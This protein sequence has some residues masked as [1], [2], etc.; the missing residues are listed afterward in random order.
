MM[1]I[2][3]PVGFLDR[4]PDLLDIP[5]AATWFHLGE[6][7]QADGKNSIYSVMDQDERRYE[8]QITERT[9]YERIKGEYEYLTALFPKCAALPYPVGF[10]FCAQGS[11]LYLQTE[12]AQGRPVSGILPELPVEWQYALGTEAGISLKRIHQARLPSN[13]V[14]RRADYSQRFCR[15]AAAYRRIRL[16]LPSIRKL[17]RLIESGQAAAVDRQAVLLH[18]GFRL[19]NLTVSP[20]M[21]IVFA[22][23]R[24]WRYGDPMQDLAN[25]LLSMR[26]ASVPFAIGILDAYFCFRMYNV[27]L[28]LLSGYAALELLEQ[29]T[30]ACQKERQSANIWLERVES[31]CRDFPGETGAGPCWYKVIR[32]AINE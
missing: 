15:A 5:G 3:H 12:R 28:T 2:V 17:L 19:E 10:G 25:A 27:I 8:L 16:P 13:R 7:T 21:T 23:L 22:S 24:S 1:P 26:W 11:R 18:G 29:Y 31:F 32:K 14:V 9:N 20:A 4:Y 6:S 30:Q